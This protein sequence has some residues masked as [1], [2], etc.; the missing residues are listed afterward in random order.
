MRP[1]DAERAAIA[2]RDSLVQ[3]LDA[4]A[5]KFEVG[6]SANSQDIAPEGFDVCHQPPLSCNGGQF[7]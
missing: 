7:C 4:F 5:G 2:V 3:L 6:A 1:E